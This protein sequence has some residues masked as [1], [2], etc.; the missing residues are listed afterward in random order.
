[1]KRK[2]QREEEERAMEWTWSAPFSSSLCTFCFLHSSLCCWF[3]S[4]TWPNSCVIPLPLQ[5]GQIER[6]NQTEQRTL[7]C[8]VTPRIP[9]I[10]WYLEWTVRLGYVVWFLSG[11]LNCNGTGK[12]NKEQSEQ[13]E[14]WMKNQKNQIKLKAKVSEK[15]T[16]ALL[17]FNLLFC[18]L[19]SCVVVLLIWFISC[20]PHFVQ[21]IINE[22]NKRT[23]N[24]HNKSSIWRTCCV[25]VLLFFLSFSCN[26][27]EVKHEL[28]ERRK[29]KHKTQLRMKREKSTKEAREFVKRA[30]TSLAS[31][32]ILLSFWLFSPFILP[33]WLLP[34][35]LNR[36]TPRDRGWFVLC[37]H[38]GL[39]VMDWIGSTN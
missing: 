1:M 4:F 15:W 9:L 8:T 11:W 2:E 26:G 28:N 12:E 36:L 7:D 19:H 37:V 6:R 5:L 22:P 21:S 34:S 33:S 20:F 17:L 24:T 16:H 38:F 18:A 3:L 14:K 30:R 32:H 10:W 13:E 31:L 23:K 39:I 35:R 25:I 27:K 29:E